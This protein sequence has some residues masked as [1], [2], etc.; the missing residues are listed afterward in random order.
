[1]VEDYL[2]PSAVRMKDMEVPYTLFNGLQ[3][4]PICSSLELRFTYSITVGLVRFWL[5]DGSLV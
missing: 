4:T 5:H 1:M 2:L 3:S